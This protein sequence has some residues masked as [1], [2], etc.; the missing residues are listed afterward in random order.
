MTKGRMKVLVIA[1]QKGGAGKTTLARHLAVAAEHN[2][3]GP[4]AL[5]DADPQGGLAKWW[6]RRSKQGQETPAFVA[7]S[8]AKLDG[9]LTSLARANFALV[10]IDT[11]PQVSGLIT[12]LVA[13]ADLVLV[14]V[15]PSPDDLDAVGSTIQIVEAA[16]KPMVF[17]VNSATKKAKITA[18]AAIKLSQ[19]GTVAEP[20]IH[21]SVSFPIS[22]AAGLTVGEQDPKSA[23]AVEIAELWTYVATKFDKA[24]RRYE[25]A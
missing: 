8:L 15:R 1:Q 10:V 4:V 20:I 19:H 2:G 25:L 12:S 16:R 23:S 22:A 7:T 14:P 5:I 6:N 9:H 13:I 18:S 11:P 21:H 24:E 17:V 3:G